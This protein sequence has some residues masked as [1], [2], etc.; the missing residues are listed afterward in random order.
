MLPKLFG[1]LKT[2]STFIANSGLLLHSWYEKQIGLSFS[3]PVEAATHYLKY[4]E[5]KGLSPHP[6]FDPK[7]QNGK[8]GKVRTTGALLSYLRDGNRSRG[9]TSPVFDAEYYLAQDQVQLSTEQTPLQHYLLSGWKQHLKPHPMFDPQKYLALHTD[10][11]QAAAEPLSHFAMHGYFEG[12]S[13]SPFYDM[14][15][16][17]THFQR[18]WQFE[19]P[20]F[21]ALTD[22]RALDI[23]PH[24][25]FASAWYR[26]RYLGS[27]STENALQHFCLQGHALGYWPN[28]LFDTQWYRE[29]HGLTQDQNP[30]E[31]YLIIGQLEKL[32]VHPLLDLAWY[33]A[34][35]PNAAADQEIPIAAHYFRLGDKENR[36]PNPTFFSGWYH[37]RNP[38]AKQER[39]SALE[40]YQSAG[41]YA[42]RKPNPLFDADWFS[43]QHMLTEDDRTPYEAYASNKSEHLSPCPLFE[44]N[45]YLSRYTDVAESGANPL[46]HFLKS[47]A[48]EHRSP[49][50]WFDCAYYSK[51]NPDVA[52]A[53][54]NPLAHFL[55]FGLDRGLDP[56]P[57]IDVHWLAT[58]PGKTDKS[59]SLCDALLNFL[60][61]EDQWT[62]ASAGWFDPNVFTQSAY[63]SKQFESPFHMLA[64][65]IIP[66][67]TRSYIYRYGVTAPI[68]IADVVRNG[69]PT[70]FDDLPD[71]S[72]SELESW[73]NPDIKVSVVMPTWNR[74]DSVTKAIQSVLNQT[75]KNIELLVV[76]DGSTDGSVELIN[77]QFASEIES[78]TI[79]LLQSNHK[80]VSHARN[81]GLAHCSGEII[82]YLDS[83]NEWQPAT[84]FVY[85]SMLQNQKEFQCLYTPIDSIN[86]DTK[87]HVV[88]GQMFD[89][90]RLLKSNYIDLNGFCHTREL[91][92][93][94]GG[95]DEHLKR[96]VDWELI[97]RFTADQPPLFVPIVTTHYLLSR[98]NLNNITFSESLVENRDL[99]IDQHRQE[100]FAHGLVSSAL[101]VRKWLERD[102]PR[103]GLPKS[104]TNTKVP[105][106]HVT[107]TIALDEVEDPRPDYLQLLERCVGQVR[108]ISIDE[109]TDLDQS[110]FSP[111]NL[112]YYPR[113]LATV[114]S[115]WSLCQAVL[116]C[117]ME[118]LDICIVSSEEPDGKTIGCNFLRDSAIVSY[119]LGR[120]FLRDKT[121]VRPFRGRIINSHSA[122]SLA[123]QDLSTVLRYPVRFS[124]DKRTFWSFDSQC[125]TVSLS[126]TSINGLAPVI[127]KKPV[128]LLIPVKTSVGGVENL[129]LTLMKALGDRYD[130]VYLALENPGGGQ[131]SMATTLAKHCLT[132]ID[133]AM[134]TD[135]QQYLPL[136][137]WI[138]DK[139][140]PKAVVL[141]N[142]SIWISNHLAD[143]H[144]IFKKIPLIDHRCYDDKVGWIQRFN[145]EPLAV[146]DHFVAVTTKI[147]Q[148]FVQQYGID[149]GKISLIAHPVDSDRISTLHDRADRAISRDKYQ[150]PDDA[151]VMV[152][153][154]R[155]VPQKDP[156]KFLQLAQKRQEIADEHFILVGSG[157]LA[158]ACERFVHSNNLKNVTCLPFVEN[159]PELFA[160]CDVLIMSSKFEAL[161]LVVVE[162][163]ACAVPVL[164]TN[165]G[166]IE[167]VVSRHQGG[168]IV[169]RE[170]TVIELEHGLTALRKKHESIKTHLAKNT[171][172]V[173]EEFSS[174]SIADQYERLWSPNR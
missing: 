74:R 114:A 16:I 172:R 30:L 160:A 18:D 64:S 15:F 96:L 54:L 37:S 75:H 70:W 33:E 53:Q 99:I 125:N 159:L 1:G 121:I 117:A 158:T 25:L 92:E 51:T 78:K 98:S 80:G 118:S 170:A 79:V 129:T 5:S 139:Y 168:I 93:E 151:F 84:L 34:R 113:S 8:P 116:A 132:L 149:K 65:N 35:Y 166:D 110:Y 27:D 88:V 123:N 20:F 147:R 2:R 11:K 71:K 171:T 104:Q 107:L 24:P 130:F 82:A 127:G 39:M 45:W 67:D 10:V 137:S 9:S 21:F 124:P 162:A 144:R 174:K 58:G 140:C 89:R 66:D 69:L 6:L 57:L 22:G 47:G 148:A 19:N 31:H 56:H 155:L 40:H 13:P 29:T 111:G 76:D 81:V 109:H 72:K 68:T 43:E 134:I 14:S 161:P 150:I 59:L 41:A 46:R 126:K 112:F 48:K 44:P 164:S 143:I 156:L 87:E 94:K 105:I 97:I 61:S 163:L 138:N 55:E 102:K 50:P 4:G 120:Q 60:A 42:G 36:D 142:G 167:P 90:T 23:D 91:Y 63:P 49:S 122:E 153:V 95:F 173:L 152:F 101:A 85:V 165:V 38:Q 141:L 12:R 145:Q 108:V 3:D 28:P 62:Q 73:H 106:S 133:G 32:E 52:R 135:R 26:K 100:F 17:E 157:E 128:I 83:D 154:G 7:W 77:N 119:R 115:P 103:S 169:D 146:F 86:I 136:M 131:K